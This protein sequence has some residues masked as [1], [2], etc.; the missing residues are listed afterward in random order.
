M[1]GVNSLV[2]MSLRT[3]V[4]YKTNLWTV[5]DCRAELI[6]PVIDRIDSP[7]QL[8]AL[9]KSSP[10]LLGCTKESWIRLLKRDIKNLDSRMPM[11]D[12][13]DVLFAPEHA[14][15]WHKIYFRL[16]AEVDKET[17]AKADALADT[18]RGI[19]NAREES[20]SAIVN[21]PLMK[22][23]SRILKTSY[24]I[25]KAISGSGGGWGRAA[26]APKKPFF[27]NLKSAT[28]PRRKAN[29]NTPM[30]L[31][32]PTFN[33]EVKRAPAALVEE[34]Q[35][36]QK[37]DK[38][39][40]ENERLLKQ[41]E[42]QQTRVNRSAGV[43]KSY[44]MVQDREARLRNL[45]NGTRTAKP[46]KQEIAKLTADFL[47]SDDED[48]HG[49]QPTQDELDEDL[50]GPTSQSPPKRVIKPIPRKRSPLP[51][52]KS[53]SP[54]QLLTRLRDERSH[55]APQTQPPQIHKTVSASPPP[56]STQ[57]T[58]NKLSPPL[59]PNTTIKR[60][61]SPLFRPG[62]GSR[63]SPAPVIKKRKAEDILFRPAKKV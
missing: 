2:K 33:R 11:D 22:Q 32:K 20:S 8:R 48:E 26:G 50:F 39:R 16:K 30:H 45:K 4:K 15:K 24:D 53:H 13:Q 35:D 36:R 14:R 37:M 18:M 3:C 19:N 29:M 7:E 1:A 43:T 38:A 23:G 25:G 10:Q 51:Q 59:H 60:A 17:K 9:E 57:P 49:R 56:R 40:E 34:L 28:A 42:A 47:E 6:K 62:A 31:L 61:A 46:T 55:R 27:E 21:K 44:D 5:G 41:R 54:P 58:S 63:A 12:W 52:P